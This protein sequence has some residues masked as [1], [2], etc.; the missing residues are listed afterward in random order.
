MPG[1]GGSDARGAYSETSP[2]S[3]GL[4][5]FPSPSFMVKYLLRAYYI[6]GIVLGTQEDQT[7]R[8]RVRRLDGENLTLANGVLRAPP[9]LSVT[10]GR[11]LGLTPWKE[12]ATEDRQHS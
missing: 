6:P 8:K 1:D 11:P 4:V 9:L 5:L 10:Q 2:S 12:T 3:Y 7:T